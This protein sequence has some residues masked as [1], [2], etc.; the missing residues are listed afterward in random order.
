MADSQKKR[1][2]K[3]L[4]L[5]QEE[6]R[7]E[8]VANVSAAPLDSNLFEWHCNIRQEDVIYHLILFMPDNYPFQSP[9]AEFMPQGFAFSGGATMSGKK[10]T[11]VCLNIFSDFAMFHNEWKNQKGYGWSPGYTT[12]TVLMNLVAFLAETAG[13]GVKSHNASLSQTFT[14]S[15]CGHTYSKPFPPLGQ[16]APETKS[17]TGK[18]KAGKGASAKNSTPPPPPPPPPPSTPK[19]VPNIIDYISKARFGLKKPQSRD[20]L[21][22]Y[23]LVVSGP[24]HRPFLTTPCEFLSGESFFSMKLSM[25]VVHSSLKE[26]LRFFLPM[27]IHPTHGNEIKD[28]F[29]ETVRAVGNML[30][31]VT[32]TATL[33]EMIVK[34]IP[35]LMAATV[36]EFSKGT[37]HTSDNSLTGYF[38]LH[39]LLL[40][41]LDTYPELQPL[42]ELRLKEFIDDEE[43]RTKKACPH[44][45]EWLMLL[46]ASQKYRWTEAAEAYLYESL[47]RNVMWFVKDNEKLGYL[48][49][50]KDF[51]IKTTFTKTEVSRK[52]LAFQ[53]LF[54]DIALPKD[55]S[56]KQIVERYDAHFGFPT[57]K[58]VSEMKQAC[59]IIKNKMATYDDWFKVLK[60]KPWPKD[61]LFTKLI[62]ALRFSILHDGYH[63]SFPKNAGGWR[64]VM[65]RYKDMAQ[66]YKDGAATPSS[67]GKSTPK[68]PTTKPGKEKEADK[69]KI[70]DSKD[71][72]EEAEAKGVKGR[73][74]G[75]GQGRGAG[76]GGRRG[77]KAKVEKAE[78]EEEEMEEEEAEEK[79]HRGRGRG[80]KRGGRGGGKEKVE[81]EE[82]E[83]EEEE[84]EEKV[85][86][87]RGRG[88]GSKRGGRGGG[89]EKVES[90]EEEEEE[91]EEKVHRGR[92]RG[93]GSKRG[94]RGGKGKVEKAESEEEEEEEEDKKSSRGR[95]R[96][97]GS[98]RGAT[99]ASKSP[100][101]QRKKA[102]K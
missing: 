8:P 40:W 9:S 85:H 92:G 84:A 35:N 58:M 70:E 71:E 36:V 23:G 88:R 39:R 66:D 81:S 42:V 97:R 14:C 74:Q 5:D 20:D 26:E 59:D 44:I 13:D 95:G 22:G 18:G 30:P 21:Y 6:L 55:M 94:G 32:K 61:A 78:S 46:S 64:P 25:G 60:L 24:P 63:W 99:P 49:T 100:G 11:K 91:A 86:R 73:G 27:F 87:G 31:S 96:G 1:A 93:R 57:P 19:N 98:K 29:E 82:E 76:R 12:Q 7:Q 17:Y 47:R 79:V 37:Q 50:D 83:E 53:V 68:T 101:P 51:R 102:R 77:G 72:E 15:D 2:M 75:R 52:I 16:S 62:E 33:E 90:E 89:K 28:T 67:S 48:D 38:A 54:L 56:R 43:K 34:T 3:R 4:I 65:A 41:A 69:G 80:S 45:G 10:G